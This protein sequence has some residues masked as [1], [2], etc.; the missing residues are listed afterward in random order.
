MVAHQVAA[1]A[2]SALVP[3]PMEAK[4]ATTTS[5]NDPAESQDLALAA[6]EFTTAIPSTSEELATPLSNSQSNADADLTTIEKCNAEEMD[7][8][9]SAD[10]DITQ[11]STTDTLISTESSTGKEVAK[12]PPAT[13]WSK[14]EDAHQSSQDIQDET[15]MEPSQAAAKACSFPSASYL[16]IQTELL[17][18]MWNSIL[19][20]AYAII[21]DLC[22]EYGTSCF[23]EGYSIEE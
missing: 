17:N 4:M 9:A 1:S 16:L 10:R 21:I 2:A 6:S 19:L 12:E 3:Q 22:P 15:S 5:N 23:T 8:V 13:T 11:E 18:F 14:S 20:I 7:T